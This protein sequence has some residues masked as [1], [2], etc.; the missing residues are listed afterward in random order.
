MSSSTNYIVIE[1]S[2]RVGSKIKLYDM[3]GKE[4]M[5]EK[6]DLEEGKNK[7]NIPA[8]ITTG[9]YFINITTDTYEKTYK[10]YAE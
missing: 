4:L 6:V 3:N 7:L 8:K 9:M 1:S 5:S 10:L 2:Y